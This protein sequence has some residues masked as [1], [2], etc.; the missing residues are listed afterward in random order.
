MIFGRSKDTAAKG[1]RGARAKARVAR[2]APQKEKKVN[3]SASLSDVAIP[4]STWRYK[5]IGVFF[6]C[7]FA[8]LMVRAVYLQVIDTE[9]LQE[10]GNARF[11]RV[12][13]ELPT[14]G[15]VVDRN[16]QP[17]AIS[18]PVDSIWMHPSSLLADQ[19]NPKL[20]EA[21][22]L[23]GM[24]KAS[25]VERASSRASK[26]FVYVK[27]H[28]PPAVADQVKALGV[29][30]INSVREYKRFYPAGP[31]V[32][33]VLGFTNIDNKGQEGIELAFDKVLRGKE[34]RTSVLRNNAG[35]I[36]EY[37]EQLEQVEHGESV[38]LSIDARIQ[39]LAYRQLQSAAEQ[40]GAENASIVVLDAKTG[41][42][43]AMV[44][45]PDFNPNDRSELTSA[46]FR[47]RAIADAFEPG[48]TMKPFSVGM[49]LDA[50]LI[51]STTIIDVE[52]GRY[53]IGGHTVTDT[54]KLGEITVSE[55]LSKSSNVGAAKVA[56]MLKPRSL[57][58]TYKELG[59]GA[60]NDL[61]VPGEQKGILVN[62]KRWR[63][64][65]HATLSYG[66]GLSANTLQ[67][68]RAYTSLTNQGEVLP[69][70]LTPIKTAPKGKRVFKPSTVESI[71][72]MLEIAVSDEGTAP[73]A[74]VPDYRVAGKTG[75]AH[76]V[77]DGQYQDDSYMSLFAGFAPV[78][79]P[80]LIIVVTVNDPRGI[81]YYGGLVAAPVF[82]AVMS[83]ALR[84]RGVLPDAVEREEPKP[85]LMITRPE[86][87][88]LDNVRVA[89]GAE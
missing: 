41:E 68:A 4:V 49:T 30:G 79:D 52:Q 13:K 39:Y 17:L 73:K 37:V 45:A 20:K 84:L 10:Q 27:R 24:S 1:G 77:V 85:A 62:R 86:T 35:Q 22:S 31:V 21:A 88:R 70:S 28:I 65:E 34:G 57:F 11:L 32:G 25:I 83:G 9:Y 2:S 8:G 42:I 66:Y 67:V 61:V 12:Q 23:L 56:M 54:K 76:R 43:L 71:N 38:S 46:R 19:D 14:R 44:S 87:A 81:D 6:F 18:T 16:G 40:H 58:N 80:E 50:G 5:V 48:S 33:H 82:S 47:N 72:R 74:R 7:S 51:D 26:Q 60:T 64:I 75:T 63:P 15:M 89:G 36:V 53:A 29:K 3:V 59:F 69:V 78:S 55:V